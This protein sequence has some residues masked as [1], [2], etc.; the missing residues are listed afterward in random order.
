MNNRIWIL[1]TAVVC[2]AV[3]AL[4]VLLG[5][6]PK[7]TEIQS[8]SASL[9][10]LQGQNAAYQAELAAL[11][12]QYEDIDKVRDELEELRRGLPADADYANFIRE[13]EA[14]AVATG[15]T[16]MTYTQGAPVVY[17][18][19]VAEGADTGTAD[20]P[21][22]GGTLLALPVDMQIFSVGDGALLFLDELRTGD[23]IF[24]LGNFDLSISITGEASG[25]MSITFSA[26]IYTLVDPNAVP[27]DAVQGDD[28]APPT[29]PV[30]SPVESSSTP[31]PVST[32]PQ[33]TPL[34]TSSSTPA[35]TP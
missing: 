35:V 10:Q 31:D 20:A 24:A 33:S 28:D 22:S 6:S 25:T 23:R 8:N 18:A 34:P 32:D 7:L 2:I 5:I 29:D 19:T 14:A 12:Q 13:V 11:K 3:I 30:P 21:I 9:L 4:G 15:T 1:G 17:G 27:D 16:V 26:L